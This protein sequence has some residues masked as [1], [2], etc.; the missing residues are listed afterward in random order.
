MGLPQATTTMAATTQTVTSDHLVVFL[1]FFS[2]LSLSLESLLMITYI[3]YTYGTGAATPPPP[4][5]QHRTTTPINDDP[6]HRP[7][8]THTHFS[9][10]L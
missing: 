3:D 1:L 6:P 10:C 4:L 5:S 9:T 2:F 7:T 8:V